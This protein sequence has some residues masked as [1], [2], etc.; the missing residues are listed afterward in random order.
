[1]K[2]PIC[3]PYSSLL[4]NEI[5]FDACFCFNVLEGES[6]CCDFD[7]GLC[8]GFRSVFTEYPGYVEWQ[9]N[10]MP[11]GQSHGNVRLPNLTPG[12][13]GLIVL[14]RLFSFQRFKIIFNPTDG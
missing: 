8:D 1:M 5:V 4:R 3:S 11:G 9:N 7:N 2:A 12:Q 13:W 6:K 14:H 10:V